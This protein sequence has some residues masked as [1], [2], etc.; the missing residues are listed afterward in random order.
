MFVAGDNGL[1]SVTST[2]FNIGDRVIGG[3]VNRGGRSYAHFDGGV[4]DLYIEIG[5]DLNGSTIL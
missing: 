5:L 2:D 4:T 1:D 3:D